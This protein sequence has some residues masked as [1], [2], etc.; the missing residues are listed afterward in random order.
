MTRKPG[1]VIGY[2]DTPERIYGPYDRVE[3]PAEISQTGD[4]GYRLEDVYDKRFPWRHL[5]HN[6][7]TRI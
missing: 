2:S 1:D 4:K 5:W 3:K 6:C 7:R